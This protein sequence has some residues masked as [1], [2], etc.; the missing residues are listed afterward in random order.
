VAVRVIRTTAGSAAS[1]QEFRSLVADGL[2]A[3]EKASR[4]GKLTRPS[5]WWRIGDA[6]P[7]G[8]DLLCGNESWRFARSAPRREV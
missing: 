5:T 7:D 1:G 6:L 8:K 3:K 4:A 2:V